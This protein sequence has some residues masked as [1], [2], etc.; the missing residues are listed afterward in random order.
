MAMA[1]SGSALNTSNAARATKWYFHKLKIGTIRVNLTYHHGEHLVTDYGLASQ[2]WMMNV[3][4]MPIVL[5]Q[6]SLDHLFDTPDKIAQQISLSYRQS[7]LKQ[8]YKLLLQIDLLGNPLALTRGLMQGAKDLI[9]LPVEGLLSMDFE[10]FGTGLVK[11][12]WSLARAVVGGGLKTVGN[13]TSRAGRQLATVSF[14]EQYMREREM[15]SAHHAR[16]RHLGQGVLSGGMAL[17]RGVGEGISGLI[18]AP[19][20]GVKEQGFKGMVKGFG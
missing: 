17:A 8:V 7:L 20:E 19:Y 14:D 9:T 18:T 6:V 1:P 3:D 2:I 15:A 16:P 12:G 13:I 10:M 5:S 4:R 11:G